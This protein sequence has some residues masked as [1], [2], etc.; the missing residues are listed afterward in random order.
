MKNQKSYIS[1]SIVA[2]LLF[3]N[4]LIGQEKNPLF[5]GF[6]P[7]ITI[8]PFYEKGEFDINL[9]PFVVEL[10]LSKRIDMRFVSLSNYHFGNE[11][12][13]SDIGINTILPIFLIKKESIIDRSEGFYLGPVLGLGRNLVNNHFTITTAGEIGYM[14]K[15]E[16]RFTVSLGVQL[17]GSYFM[18]DNEPAVWR[19]HFGPKIN[20]GWWM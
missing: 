7:G 3:A 6:Q 17:G 8:E 13:F 15:A 16:R 10:P 2:F 1:I 12:G 20:L 14:F 18:Y 5:I 19:Q 9:I 4:N 11:A